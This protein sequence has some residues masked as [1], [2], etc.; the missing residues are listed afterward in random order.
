MLG[1]TIA[2]AALSEDALTSRPTLNGRVVRRAPAAGMLP[3]APAFSPRT[4]RVSKILM[5]VLAVIILAETT[6][7]LG[8]YF[9]YSRYYVVTDNAIVDGD[10][11]NI[12]APASGTI[13]RWIG[14]EGLAMRQG[15]Y[16]G[17]VVPTGGGPRPQFVVKAPANAT[18]GIND[19]VDGVN[20]AAGQTLAVAYDP[21]NVWITAR[22]DESAISRVRVGQPV[23][24]TIDAFSEIP[25]TGVVT[26]IEASTAG[27]FSV[28]PSTD[29][30]PT[31]VQ[32]VNQYVA[33][34]IV[35]TYTGGQRLLPG[36]NAAV[37]IHMS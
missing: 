14:T 2:T 19:V 3:A 9:L 7:F 15:Q 21:R 24:I 20:V 16:L 30:D 28:Y 4:R 1:P 18:V 31:N 37:H 36:M 34:R 11:I 33:V 8:T 17:R 26:L 23:D 6:A 35:P 13:R 32:K 29:T 12:N 22:V 5:I 25:M 10:A 27:Q